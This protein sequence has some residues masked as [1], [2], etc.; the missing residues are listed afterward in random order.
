MSGVGCA[1]GDGSGRWV[2]VGG[3]EAPHPCILLSRLV[4]CGWGLVPDGDPVISLAPYPSHLRRV[5]EVFELWR[6]V[7]RILSSQ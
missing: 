2:G 1:S 7:F 4:L 6:S 3:F 5:A